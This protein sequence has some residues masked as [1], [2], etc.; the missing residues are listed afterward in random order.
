MPRS[1]CFQLLKSH[2]KNL[3]CWTTKFPELKFIGLCHEIASM[4]RQLPDLMKTDFS[5]INF[6]AGGLNHF[7]VLLNVN[8]KDTG[9]DGYPIIRKNFD[10]YYSGLV[11]QHEGF[12]S[13]PGAER[14]VFKK[15]F[16]E[17]KYLPI[18]TDSHLG[19]YLQWLIALQIMMQF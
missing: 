15:L 12:K 13:K 10:D 5:N 8:Y 3:S 9:E 17:Y 16:Q 11:N 1:I 2:A 18:T 14:G 6:R 7:S 4:E 19:E